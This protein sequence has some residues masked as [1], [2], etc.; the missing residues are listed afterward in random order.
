MKFKGGIHPQY[1]KGTAAAP[2]EEM[3]LGGRYVVP[4]AQHL[5]AP[6]KP[7]VAKG[8]VV[9][10]GQPLSEPGG[11]VSVAVHAPTSGKVKAIKELPHPL[12]LDMTAVE[13]EP[14]GEDAWWEGVQPKG[15]WRGMDPAD[16]RDALREAG[17]VGMGGATFPTHVKL[18]P[19]REKP[20]DALILNGAECEPY[21]TLSLIHI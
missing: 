5:G 20:I 7:I 2:V 12:G 16:I 13:I 17:L 19:P 15:D 21:L 8:D 4:L 10:R 18:S 3:P 14:D 11:F 9:G 1:N 6:G